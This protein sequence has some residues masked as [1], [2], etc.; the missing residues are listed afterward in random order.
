MLEEGKFY[1][2]REIHDLLGGELQTYL[3]ARGGLVTCACLTLKRNPDAPHTILVGQSPEFSNVQNNSVLRVARSRCSSSETQ[4]NG[5][6]LGD[7]KSSAARQMQSTSTSINSF[8]GGLT[9]GWSCSSRSLS[10]WNS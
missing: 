6:T 5:N 8:P 7:T 9:S 2:R 1:S 4:T 3:P 10:S